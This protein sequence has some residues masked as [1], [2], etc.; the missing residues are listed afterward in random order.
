VVF[1]FLTPEGAIEREL[2]DL[3]DAAREVSDLVAAGAEM[4]VD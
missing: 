1:V 4:M 3:T 2:T